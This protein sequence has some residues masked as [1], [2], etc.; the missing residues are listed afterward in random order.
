MNEGQRDEKE[1]K[2]KTVAL[3]ACSSSKEGGQLPWKPSLVNMPVYKSI[4]P[5]EKSYWFY[6]S[7]IE[8]L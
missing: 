3:C 8:S 6:K 2:E 4:G 5:V 1:K 7:C